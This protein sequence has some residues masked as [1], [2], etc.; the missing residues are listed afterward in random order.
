MRH[1]FQELLIAVAASAV[2]ELV[3]NMMLHPVKQKRPGEVEV[4]RGKNLRTLIAGGVP[5]GSGCYQ[6]PLPFLHGQVFFSNF[7]DYC[8]IFFALHPNIYQ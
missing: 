4:H 5:G 8:N 7:S 6:H 3:H 1:F 2:A